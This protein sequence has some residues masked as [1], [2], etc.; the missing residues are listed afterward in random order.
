MNQRELSELRRRFRADRS[1][2]SRI[3]GCYVNSSKEV[4]SY[5]D[6]SLG[7]M[8]QEEAEKYLGLLKKALSGTLGR[9][10]IDIE[11][12]TQQVRN[13]DE[14]RLLSALRDSGLKDGAV[15]QTFYQKVIE[16]LDM[17]GS[18]YLILLAHD[19]YDVPYRGKDDETQADA[20][21]QVFSYIVCCVCPV[22]DSKVE[23]GYFPGENEFHNYATGQIVAAPELG[24][25]FPAFDDRA[26]NI[27]NALFYS[28]KTDVLHQ[29]FIDAVF[30]TEPPLSA[31]EQR[32]AFETALSEALEDDCSMEVVQSVHEQLTQRIEQHKASK[33]PEPLALTAREVG[34]ILSE[35]GVAE[36]RVDAFCQKCGEQFGDGAALSPGNLIDSKRFEIKT[37][38]ATITVDPEYSCFVETRIING[39]KYILIPADEGTQINGL[40]VSFSSK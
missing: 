22:K 30:H 33:D 31:G 39:K 2:I 28:H 35:C 1:A 27:Y 15:R 32:E 12:S 25:L 14:H 11:F 16:S 34:G 9:N 5:I 23:L 26:A 17:D 38:H 3:Y 18:N 20:S 19:I 10:L 21:D 24:F 29:E 8:P 4:I 13:S 6:A 36:E 7:V 37:S 40:H